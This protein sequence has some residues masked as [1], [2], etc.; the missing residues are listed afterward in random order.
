VRSLHYFMVSILVLVLVAFVAVG[1]ALRPPTS[2]FPS[3]PNNL[4][5]QVMAPGVRTLTERLV[6]RA[7]G[8]VQLIVQSDQNPQ[9]PTLLGIYNPAGAR[10]C[11]PKNLV[12]FTYSGGNMEELPMPAFKVQDERASQSNPDA[13]VG[14]VQEIIVNSVGP[15]VD[16]YICFP[17]T[18][19]VRFIG[20]YLSAQFPRVQLLSGRLQD[21]RSVLTLKGANTADFSIQ[22]PFSP[23][24]TNA[25]SWTWSQAASEQAIHLSAIDVST[26]QY[27]NHQAFLSGIALGI[28]GGALIT[29]L[30]ELVAP[31]SRRKDERLGG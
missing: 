11:T 5:L 13:P 6:L 8:S 17:R 15:G 26:S 16:V 21:L 30:Q 18:T 24:S 28:A 2:G 29:I 19:P 25:T 27:E 31:F 7:D 3:V 14:P 20:A 23:S 4:Y 10:V 9:G 22:S 1:W 12:R